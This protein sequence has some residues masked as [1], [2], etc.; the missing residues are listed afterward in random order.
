MYNLKLMIMKK[1]KILTTMMIAFVFISGNIFA[2][3][4]AETHAKLTGHHQAV[5]KHAKA[6]TS[7]DAKTKDE[8]ILHANEAT[9]SLND[10]KKTLEELIKL[11]PEE[12]KLI[13]KPYNEKIE[14][15]YVTAI[16]HAQL[17]NEE[18]KKKEHDDAKV[19][20]HAKNLHDAIE[21]AEKEHQELMEK[22]K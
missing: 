9:K 14:A 3:T 6:I 17:L 11:I 22:T 4:K 7:G 16:A 8:Q 12:F 15:L 13:A 19:K 2:Q 21:K 10:A 1:K 20:E 18:L 5:M